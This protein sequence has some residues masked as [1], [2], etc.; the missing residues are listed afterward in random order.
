M[1]EAESFSSI[2][3]TGSPD[4]PALFPDTAPP[5]LLQLIEA[6]LFIA[7]EPV[8]VEQLARALEAPPEQV[9][10]ALDE[11]SA[12]YSQ[13]GIR[14]QRHG[15][16]MMLVSAPEAAPVIRRFLGAQ[17]GHRLS[18][19]ALETLAIIAYRQP[20]TRAQI[21]AIRGV[22]SSAALR[23]LLA[24]DLIC[25]AGRLETLGRPILYATTAT[26]LQQFGLTSLSDLPPVDLPE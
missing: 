16:Q 21:D 7:G 26:F 5:S 12:S 9:A 25:E 22:D 17:S 19:A 13:R 10:A 1:S 8:T 6:V 15:D 14:L 18:N 2:T 3:P 4:Q 23:A 20:I 11:L 24:R